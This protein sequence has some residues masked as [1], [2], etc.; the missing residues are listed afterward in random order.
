MITPEEGAYAFE[1]LVRH[2]RAYSGYIPILGAPWLADLVRRSPWGEMF[3]STGQ[4]SRGPSKF[5]ME[6]LSLPQDEWAGRLRRLLVE[7]ASVILRRTIDADRSFI[8]Y[9]LDSLGMLEMRTHVE[10]ETGIRLTPKVIATNNTARALAQYLAD[11][12][13]EE[14]AAAP[15]AS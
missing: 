6:L 15:A 8:E 2:D 9:G 11:T 7:Q 10:T 12:L 1:T 4:R 5:R 3:A 13:A 14:Q